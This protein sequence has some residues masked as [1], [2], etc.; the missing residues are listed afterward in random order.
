MLISQRQAVAVLRAGPHRPTQRLATGLLVTGFAGSAITAGGMS[1]YDEAKVRDRA[2]APVVD[3]SNLPEACRHGV[4][5][6][7]MAARA[8]LA[9]AEEP[10]RLEAARRPRPF[11]PI[12]R[13]WLAVAREKW[14]VVPVVATVAG[15]VL[16][17]AEFLDCH[18]ADEDARFASAQLAEAGDW[19]TAFTHRVMWTPPG[20][21]WLLWKPAESRSWGSAFA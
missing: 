15:H 16:V 6:L 1:L 21:S 17:T 11:S 4:L 5:V 10:A 20:N 3:T 14:G 7:R 13:V 9:L 8:G 19:Q 18:G 12:M 2:C